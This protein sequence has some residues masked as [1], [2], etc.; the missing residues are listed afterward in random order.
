M[1]MEETA[2]DDVLAIVDRD[3][4]EVFLAALNTVHEKLEFTCEWEKT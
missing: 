2:W 1:V 4:V 3:E